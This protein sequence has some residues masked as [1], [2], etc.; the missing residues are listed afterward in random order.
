MRA[1]RTDIQPELWVRDGPAAVEFY[2]QALGAVVEHRVVG[3][4][5]SDVIAQL[6]VAGARLDQGYLVVSFAGETSTGGA[7]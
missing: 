3:P 5:D 6:S 4:E 7:S 2:E 1:P